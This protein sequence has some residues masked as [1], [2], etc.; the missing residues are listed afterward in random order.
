M[1]NDSGATS[2]RG[3][4]EAKQTYV[5]RAN[6]VCAAASQLINDVLDATYADTA[7]TS[8]PPAE[9]ERMVVDQVAP[10]VR[11][12]IL[13]LRHRPPPPGDDTA[14][15]AIYAS[16]EQALATVEH[17]PG[18][19]RFYGQGTTD[20]PFSRPATLAGDYGLDVCA[21]GSPDAD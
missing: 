10:I 21:L 19:F 15:A 13:V 2:G 14:V 7:R 9:R 1:A 4:D 3:D 12:E 18:T 8:A 20:D 16:M 6:H 11:A 17:D 5:D